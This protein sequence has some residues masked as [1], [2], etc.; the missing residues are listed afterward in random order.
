[1]ATYVTYVPTTTITRAMFNFDAVGAAN[2]TYSGP[3]RVSV[4]DSFSVDEQAAL[5]FYSAIYTNGVADVAWAPTTLTNISATLDIIE[6]FVNVDFQWRGDIDTIA[7]DSVINPLEVAAAD[8]SD[9][10]ISL[11]R[12]G[13][14][15][16]VGLAG[17]DTDVDL[18]YA[19][20]AGDVFVNEFYLQETT[21]GGGTPSRSTLIHELL[22]SL[23][24]SHPHSDYVGDIP[25]ITADYSATRN[26]GFAKLGFRTA[27]AA[28]MYKEYFS[29]MSYADDSPT[30][31]PHTPMILDVIAL[32]QAY[33]EGKGTHTA[34]NDTVS[35]GNS[36]YRVYFDKGGV[37]TIDLGFLTTGA[38][39]H[40]GVTI[41]GAAHLVGVAMTTEDA[42]RLSDPVGGPQNL[43]W[44]YGEYEHATGSAAADRLIGNGLANHI[45]G[46][47]G[48]DKIYGADGNDV[49]NGGLD[50]DLI[51]G[52]A[53]DDQLIGGTGVDTADYASAARAVVVNLALSVSQ[54]TGGAGRDTLASI[55]N[56]TG[57]IYGDHL[58]GSV[59]TNVLSGGRGDD[60]LSG[61][62]GN[63]ILTGGAGSDKLRG[64]PG[65]DYFLF[66]NFSFI[67]RDHILDFRG[68]DDTIRLDNALFSKLLNHGALAA[69][70][71]Q[72]NSRGVALDTN[73]F[74]VFNTHSGALFYDADG[75]GAG[76]AI[77][78]ATLYDGHG[79]HLSA[80]QLAPLD[81]V[82]V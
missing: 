8:L 43:R 25:T 59:A 37:D 23:G 62:A 6:Q 72:E 13:D 44:F 76:R 80:S 39:L 55:E 15:D 40:M 19:G 66:D 10:N 11:I 29:I 7:G 69:I 16:W 18:D 48:A 47:A 65:K 68:V 31:E 21:F 42:L 27:T 56:L 35:V 38:Y 50:A 58:S 4:S 51:S 60:I 2:Y 63:D 78:F 45:S 30:D 81:F 46:L 67:G 33:G 74:I 41:T 1:M 54:P 3:L 9:I 57:S 26:L 52:G 36:G 71:Y 20:A 34:G 12:R 61:D 82:V 70:N 32:Q 53:G 24:L 14:I 79:A 77:H 28:D 22:H 17:G 73:D 64:G 5:R 75:N 49:L